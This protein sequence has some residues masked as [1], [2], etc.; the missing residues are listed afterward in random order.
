MVNT[1]YVPLWHISP[2]QHV[3]YTLVRNQLH[4]DLLF[5]DM[6]KVDQFLSIEG[7]AAQV[8]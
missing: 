5:E 2:F 7:A 3:H 4:M 6:N 1:N 8:D